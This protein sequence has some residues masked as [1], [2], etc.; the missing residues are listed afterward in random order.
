MSLADQAAATRTDGAPRRCDS[1][2][3]PRL[4]VS[5]SERASVPTSP[6]PEVAAIVEVGE[7]LRSASS[8]SDVF[9]HLVE[10]VERVLPSRAIAIA[11]ATRN[12]EPF[13]WTSG[14]SGLEPAHVATVAEA[15][16]DYFHHDAELDELDAVLALPEQPWVALPVAADDGTILGLFAIAP[17]ERRRRGQDRVRRVRC[18]AP[19]RPPRPCR[20]APTR[21]RRTRACRMARAH[22]RP[23]TH[24][25]TTGA[26]RGGALP[27]S[28]PHRVRRDGDP[29]LHL[30]LPLGAT[31]RRAHRRD[32]PRQRMCHRRRGGVRP[33]AL[34]ARPRPR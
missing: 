30:R 12:S 18:E 13:V 1:V 24:R 21:L 23:P 20:A 31:A 34:R 29:S 16:L 33:R 15:M 8:P 17:A 26:H 4:V 11:P 22:E 3:W 28:A 27:A 2:R 7:L 14:A 10:I 25:G 5:P 19:R 6:P 32:Q 9:A